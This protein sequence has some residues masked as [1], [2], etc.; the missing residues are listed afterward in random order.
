LDFR[1][2]THLQVAVKLGKASEVDSLFWG[3][4]RPSLGDQY[5][6]VV[7]CEAK[8]AKDPLLEDQIVRQVRATFKSVSPLDLNVSTVVPIG[9]KSVKGGK[10][11]VVEFAPWTKDEADDPTKNELVAVS[12][13]LYELLPPVPGVGMT[14]A[15]MRKWSRK[16]AI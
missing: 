1:E 9:L 3:V 13:G 7:T 6:V 15:A 4:V 16:P 10:V 8:Q 5:N 11:Y 14:P 2:L 12:R